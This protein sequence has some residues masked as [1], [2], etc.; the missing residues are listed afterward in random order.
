MMDIIGLG[1]A[2]LDI[3]IRIKDMP[4]WQDCGSFSG[5]EMDGGGM[6]AT[7]CVAAAKL[8]AKVGF[9]GTAGDDENADRKLRSFHDAGVDLSRM[10]LRPGPEE[11]LVLVYV[12]EETGERTF[13]GMRRTGTASRDLQIGELDKPYIQSAKFLHIDGCHHQAALQAAQWAHAVGMQVCL[14]GTKTNG[15]PLNPNMLD[16]ILEVDILI[17]AS[18]FAQSLTGETDPQK[19]RTAA[20]AYGP[21]IVVQTE[22]EEGCYTFTAEENFHTPAYHVDVLDTTGAGDVFHGA[23]LVGMLQGWDL[24]RI[25][26]FASAVS[27]IKCQ[28]MGGRFG[29][30]TYDQTLEFLRKNDPKW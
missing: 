17:C 13:S 4:T 6:A 29:I 23:Y 11:Q 9:I 30:P 2:T 15:M 12:Q 8:G 18:G 1:L 20:L 28:F 14:D 3:L 10:A 24:S 26:K 19:A 25:A 16:L 7:A 27:A 22:G 5:F 21:S